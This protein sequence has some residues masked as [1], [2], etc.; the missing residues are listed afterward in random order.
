MHTIFY[1]PAVT[2]GLVVMFLWKD[3]LF[4]PGSHGVLNQLLSPLGIGNQTWLNDPEGIVAK[5]FMVFGINIPAWAAGPSMAMLCVVIPGIWAAVGPGS[6]IYIVALKSIPRILY[7][8]AEVEGATFF[9]KIVVPEK[10]IS[11]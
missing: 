2:T 11:K 9:T 7:E 4:D 1:L 8:A 3:L 10:V 6:I 5:L